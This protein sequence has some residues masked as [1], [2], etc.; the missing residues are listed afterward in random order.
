MYLVF[1]YL[2]VTCMRDQGPT[3]GNTDRSWSQVEGNLSTGHISQKPIEVCNSI[4]RP[5]RWQR[6]RQ[7]QSSSSFSRAFLYCSCPT[8]NLHGPFLHPYPYPDPYLYRDLCSHHTAITSLILSLANS[9]ALVLILAE[10]RAGPL[11]YSSIRSTTIPP[12]PTLSA[13]PSPYD[14][15]YSNPTLCLAARRRDA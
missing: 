3:G 6:Q 13:N 1:L 11:S 8:C 12:W 15:Q 5:W 4:P 2:A 7:R 14:L 9:T 10:Y